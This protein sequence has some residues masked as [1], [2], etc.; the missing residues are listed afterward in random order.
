MRK[1]N[2]H[3]LSVSVS[4]T[5][6][7]TSGRNLGIGGVKALKHTTKLHRNPRQTG[8]SSK[9]LRSCL[10]TLKALLASGKG[11]RRD[12]DDDDDDKGVGDCLLPQRK[13]ENTSPN[14]ISKQ[15]NATA[16]TKQIHKQK[17]ST[18]SSSALTALF[19]S[20]NGVFWYFRHTTRVV[21]LPSLVFV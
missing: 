3:R 2:T 13:K 1:V 20:E 16:A 17:Q 15:S 11:R 18:R 4:P 6:I 12:D 9:A 14:R 10:T 21:C 19:G 7:K 8:A 5:I